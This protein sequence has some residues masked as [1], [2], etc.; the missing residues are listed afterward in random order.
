[1]CPVLR[2]C[3]KLVRVGGAQAEVCASCVRIN[4]KAEITRGNGRWGDFKEG[5][6]TNNI[7]SF[8]ERQLGLLVVKDMIIADV[9]IDLHGILSHGS[10]LD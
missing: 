8:K 3:R 6:R 9:L 2:S 10:L 4:C 7:H 5:G 1:M